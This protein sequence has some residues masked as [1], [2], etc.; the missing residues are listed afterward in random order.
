MHYQS[1]VTA[2]SL[3]SA[4]LALHGQ[5]PI[6]IAEE[7]GARP[8]DITNSNPGHLNSI[9]SNSEQWRFDECPPE[10]ATG[11]LIFDTVHSLLQHWPNT[12]YRNGHNIVPGVI[13][14]GTLLYHGTNGSR[15]IPSGPEWTAMNPEHSIYFSRG[16]GSGWH[17]TLAATRPLK[18]L[19][20]DGSSAAKLS[21][22]TMD[23]QDIIAWGEPRPERSFDEGDR[24][25]ALCAWGKEFG[26]DGFVSE[27]MLCD[28]TAGVE[29]VSFVHIALPRDDRSFPLSTSVDPNTCQSSTCGLWHNRYPGDSRIV[30]DLTG[31]ISLY[32]TALA[33]SLI[34]ARAG[35]GRLDHRVFG[36]SS[37]DI[38]RVMRK[39]IKVVTR[40]HPVGSGIDWKTLLHVIV[41][42]YAD[43]LELTRYLLNVTLSDPQELLERA[44]LVQF[45]L[46]VMLTPYLLHSTAIPNTGTLGIYLSQWASPIF[47]LCVT[48]HTSQITN[49]KP[50][51]TSSELLLLKAVEDTTREICRITIKM[52]AVG[53]M[54]GFDT[55]FPIELNGEL[56]V[57]Q[58]MNDWRQDIGKLMSWLDWS[59]WIKCRPACGPEEM[60]Y[61]ST[62][63]INAPRPERPLLSP[64]NSQNLTNFPETQY[65]ADRVTQPKYP[66]MP[67]ED[68]GL[69]QPRCIRRLQPYGF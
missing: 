53:V 41:D 55:L 68:W 31:L 32:D 40:P 57:T 6:N 35:F 17:L 61:L 20:F 8:L 37:D 19:Y 47:S 4:A 63:P 48:T 62:W 39:L 66:T 24:I 15:I 58:I 42:R 34:S 21:E 46:R 7:I 36:I 59:V 25:N 67:A 60:C 26:I 50:L 27:V 51:M 29:V 13:P 5:F 18:V 43:R 22:G 45:Q 49:L 30:L 16:N 3:G 11:N 14:I 52:W 1:L 10:N 54:S 28:F 38:S 65:V 12:R 69:P 56:D 23:V 2:L 44:K 64:R 33:P 9:S